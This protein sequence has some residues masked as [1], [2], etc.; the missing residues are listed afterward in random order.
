[1]AAVPPPGT[2]VREATDEALAVLS[3]SS[4]A[5][6]RDLISE[7]VALAT[8]V[9]GYEEL[10]ARYLDR[11]TQR[12]ACDPRETVPAVFALAT[13]AGGDLRTGVEFAANFGRD[14]DT[15]ASMTGAL[16]G[17]VGGPDE[18]PEG[19]M[20]TLGPSA[21]R[22]AEELAGRLAETARAKVADR[23]RRVRSVPGLAP[24]ADG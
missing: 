2:S 6:M 23:E 14:T 1:V 16:C 24:E 5:P 9:S 22:D 13:L 20:A 15:I 21:V 19:W 17:A 7:A 11:F 3:P 10:R 18:V 4:G 8:E 12:I